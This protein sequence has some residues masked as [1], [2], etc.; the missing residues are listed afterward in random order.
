[1]DWK[2]YNKADLFHRIVTYRLSTFLFKMTNNNA[3][4]IGDDDKN[5]N[6]KLQ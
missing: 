1:M 5:V 2:P 6:N 3:N 4:D